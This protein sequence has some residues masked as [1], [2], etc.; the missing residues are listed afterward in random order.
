M[1]IDRALVFISKALFGAYPRWRGCKPEL[2]QRIYFANH[3][4]HL[5]TVVLWSA[6]PT[7]L[8]RRTRAVAARDYW[9]HGIFRGLIANQGLRAVLIDRKKESEEDPLAPVY[10]A[11]SQGRFAHLVPRGHAQS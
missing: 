7:K 6:L 11:L 5:D 9:G 2:A 1:I 4:S 3:A 10:Q 8:R